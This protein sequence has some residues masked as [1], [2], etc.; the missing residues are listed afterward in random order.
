MQDEREKKKTSFGKGTVRH[1]HFDG[2][3]KKL[4][5]KMG[6]WI[7]SPPLNAVILSIANTNIFFQLLLQLIANFL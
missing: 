1:G 4:T 2:V 7:F 5:G 6:Q 3:K